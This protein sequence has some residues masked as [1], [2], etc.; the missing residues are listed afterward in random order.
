MSSILLIEYNHP[1]RK[2]IY[3]CGD[4]RVSPGINE[5]RKDVWNGHGKTPGAKDNPGVKAMLKDEYLKVLCE[6]GE[7]IA[8]PKDEGAKSEFDKAL[9]SFSVDE[10]K[11]LVGNCYDQALLLKWRDEEKAGKQR[12]NVLSAIDNQLANI[13]KHIPPEEDKDK[14]GDKDAKSKAKK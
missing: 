3:R 4:F 10:A 12:R 7:K 1:T 13:E 8:K 14:S 2:N 5:I 9:N 6:K 11:K